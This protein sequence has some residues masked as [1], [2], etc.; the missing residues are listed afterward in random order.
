VPRVRIDADSGVWQVVPEDVGVGSRD[1]HVV[2]AVRDE[3]RLADSPE[4]SELRRIRYAPLDDRVV[5]SR[6]D[7]RAVGVVALLASGD[8]LASTDRAYQFPREISFNA[9]TSSA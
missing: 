4:P 3:R 6:Y 7:L 8:P 2:V 9:R 1:H 5:L